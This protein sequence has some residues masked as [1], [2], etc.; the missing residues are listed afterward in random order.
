MPTTEETQARLAG[1][2]N[3][4]VSRDTPLALY[5]RFGIGGP[6]DW[7]AE[8]ASAEAFIAALAA[9]RSSGLPVIVIGSG[10]NLIVSD[11]GF[12]GLVLRYRAE[13]MFASNGRVIADAG[14]VLQD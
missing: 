14:V 6:A 7:Y 5:T 8:T 3:L 11:Q 1:I 2:P 12:R 13:K 9:A 4:T 10:T